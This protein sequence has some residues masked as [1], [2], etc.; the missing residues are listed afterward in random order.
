MHTRFTLF[1]DA[2]PSSSFCFVRFTVPGCQGISSL[3][4]GKRPLEPRRSDGRIS[5]EPHEL[6]LEGNVAQE[7]CTEL[8]FSR[9]TAL[10]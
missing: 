2:L 5:Y 10:S 9:T 8:L 7:L 1:D 6:F 4:Y 3:S